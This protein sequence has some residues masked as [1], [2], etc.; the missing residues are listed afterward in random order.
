VIAVVR[1]TGLAAAAQ[2]LPGTPVRF[3]AVRRR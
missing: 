3:V 1:A 2:A